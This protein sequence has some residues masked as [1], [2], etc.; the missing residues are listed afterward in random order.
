M[1]Y[2]FDTEFDER[3][4]VIHLISIGIVAEDG[5]EYYAVSAD[6]DDTQANPWLQTHVL[7]FLSGQPRIP[8][9]QMRQ[10]VLDFFQPAP[11]EIWAYFGEYDWMVLRQLVGHMMDWPTGW[12]LSHM[13]LEQ[14]RLQLGAPKLPSQPVN[15]LHHALE[16]A[17]WCRQAWASLARGQVQSV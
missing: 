8:R 12:P 3:D 5:R 11:H 1:R 2:W 6:Y 7:P 17:R 16:D 9:S 13:N 4:Q 14:W 15:S 10:E